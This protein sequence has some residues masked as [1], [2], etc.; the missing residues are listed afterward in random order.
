MFKK[1]RKKTPQ[2][3]IPDLDR[4]EK[5]IPEQQCRQQKN[6]NVT[7]KNKQGLKTPWNPKDRQD[8]QRREPSGAGKAEM[9]RCGC[10]WIREGGA[11]GVLYSKSKAAKDGWGAT[12]GG[13]GIVAPVLGFVRESLES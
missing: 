12:R 5:K 7:Q 8:P 4:I 3:A 9:E 1:K 6:G 2:L 10:G 13:R 11:A